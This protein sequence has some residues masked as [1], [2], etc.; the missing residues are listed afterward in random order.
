MAL[1]PLSVDPERVLSA[2]LKAG[3]EDAEVYWSQSRSQPAL[4]EANRL[5]QVEQVLSDG[6]ALRVWQNGRCGLAVAYG[7]VEVDR[8]V[9]KAS[10][11]S[12]FGVE[13]PPFLAEL[14]PP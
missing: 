12:E 13:Q 14:S 7:P 10:S 11:V 1:P 9:E 8:L 4:F 3:V 5:K 2:A 6:L